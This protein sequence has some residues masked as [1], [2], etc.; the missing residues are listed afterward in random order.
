MYLPMLGSQQRISI[1]LALQKRQASQFAPEGFFFKC[2][3]TVE[4]IK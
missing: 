3:T 4:F 1:L 2:V